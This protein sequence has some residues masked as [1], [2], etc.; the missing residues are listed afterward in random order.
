MHYLGISII[1]SLSKGDPLMIIIKVMVETKDVNINTVR[2]ESSCTDVEVLVSALVDIHTAGVRVAGE[3]NLAGAV[4]SPV[5]VPAV[6][7]GLEQTGKHFNSQ[8]FKSLEPEEEKTR[9]F[10]SS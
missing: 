6:R 8:S 10:H 9:N 1:L 4:V 7:V 2:I 3:A 5:P